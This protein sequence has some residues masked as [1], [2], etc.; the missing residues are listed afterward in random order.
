MAWIRGMQGTMGG[1]PKPARAGLAAILLLVGSAHELASAEAEPRHSAAGAL[2]AANA[3]PVPEFGIK[4]APLTPELRKKYAIAHGHAAPVVTDVEP[5]GPAARKLNAG[6]AIV[7]IG[8][9]LV[10]SPQDAAKDIEA[11]RQPGRTSAVLDVVSPEGYL[12]FV[13]VPLRGPGPAAK[14]G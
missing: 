3:V 10:S 5:N 13:S 2:G 11:L 6:D 14:K 4:L 12:R 9:E 7:Q 8:S 1:L